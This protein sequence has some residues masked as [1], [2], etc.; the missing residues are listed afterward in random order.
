MY[1]GRAK[2]K[3]KT[4]VGV[5]EGKKVPTHFPRLTTNVVRKPLKCLSVNLSKFF[6][7]KLV[8]LGQEKLYPL[9]GTVP[10]RGKYTFKT[11]ME[12]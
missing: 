2:K 8:P 4:I 7:N 9:I 3:S 11:H 5:Q 6:E 12:K 10:E 1:L